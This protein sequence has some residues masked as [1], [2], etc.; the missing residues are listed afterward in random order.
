[1][2]PG[3][4]TRRRRPPNPRVSAIQGDPIAMGHSTICVTLGRY[5]PPLPRLDEAIAVTSDQG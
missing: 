4:G 3:I 5:G 2:R 1:M